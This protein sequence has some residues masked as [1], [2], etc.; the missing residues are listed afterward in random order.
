[1][2]YKSIFLRIVFF[3]LSMKY[4]LK[5]H[6]FLSMAFIEFS[7]LITGERTMVF[8]RKL[9]SGDADI[10]REMLPPNEKPMR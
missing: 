5:I 1:M 10:L 4:F 8:L 2:L 3:H 9:I 7:G 6:E